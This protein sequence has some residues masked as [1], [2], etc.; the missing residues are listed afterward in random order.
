MADWD[1]LLVGNVT[2]VPLPVHHLDMLRTPHIRLLAADLRE[3]IN[4]VLPMNG[5]IDPYRQD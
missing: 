5:L 4:K 1:Q 2:Y 3:Q